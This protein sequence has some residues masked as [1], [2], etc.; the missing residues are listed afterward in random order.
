MWDAFTSITANVGFSFENLILILVFVGGLI[1]YARDF[2]IGTMLHFIGFAL[3][4]MW[5]YEAGYT[6]GT[7]L[8][9]MFVFLIFL[10]L[11]LYAVDKSSQ[12]GALI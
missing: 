7:P 11:S 10:A 5:F 1:F 12:R 4:F 8:I 9:L 6:Y 2:R 3:V